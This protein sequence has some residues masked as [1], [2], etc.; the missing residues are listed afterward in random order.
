MII[1]L[2]DLQDCVYVACA[3]KYVIVSIGALDVSDVFIVNCA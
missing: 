3:L 1:L 2:M